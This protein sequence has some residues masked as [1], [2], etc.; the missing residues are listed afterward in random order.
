[1][2]FFS[3]HILLYSVASS[4]LSSQFLIFTY[5]YLYRAVFCYTRSF[6]IQHNP[7]HPMRISR[8]GLFKDALWKRWEVW[9][10]QQVFSMIVPIL[11]N[12]GVFGPLFSGIQD[13]VKNCSL[14]NSNLALKFGAL[15][16]IIIIIIAV[17]VFKLGFNWGNCWLPFILLICSLESQYQ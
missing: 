11:W 13:D 4:L 2:C 1:M 9:T 17:Q 8:E 7:P 3:L 10:R 12:T 16:A 5:K 15:E 6:L 14:S